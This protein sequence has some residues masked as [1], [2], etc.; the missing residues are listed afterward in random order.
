MQRRNES[1]YSKY[2]SLSDLTDPFH[3]YVGF[4]KF[5]IGGTTSDAA[6]EIRD[7]HMTREEGV[8]LVRRY[9][10]EFPAKYFKK[11][12]QYLDITEQ[13]FWN[14]VDEYRVISPHIVA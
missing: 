9:D 5:G 11:F 12:L 10:Q 14:I 6:Y 8:A 13:D 4:L 2:A 7:G 1:T 3:Y